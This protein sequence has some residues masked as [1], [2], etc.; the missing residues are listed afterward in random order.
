M[1]LNESIVQLMVIINFIFIIFVLFLN[2]KV[3]KT[4]LFIVPDD[5]SDLL[6]HFGLSN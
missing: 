1:P 3:V 2:D 4:S 6:L 5:M